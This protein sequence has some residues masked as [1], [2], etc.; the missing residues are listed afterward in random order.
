MNPKEAEGWKKGDVTLSEINDLNDH[1]LGVQ[2][3]QVVALTEAGKQ[4]ALMLSSE[5]SAK[6]TLS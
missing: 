6:L 3:I 5:K 4:L 1:D 2:M